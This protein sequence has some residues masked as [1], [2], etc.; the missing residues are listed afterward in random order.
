MTTS[1]IFWRSRCHRP[2]SC[3]LPGPFPG[4]PAMNTHNIR[5]ALFLCV[6]ALAALLANSPALA[7][8]PLRDEHKIAHHER[9]HSDSRRHETLANVRALIVQFRKTGDDQ[10]LDRAWTLLQPALGAASP[11]PETFIAASFVAQSRHEFGQATALIRQALAINAN[12]DE[13]WLLLASIQ[14]VQGDAAS[15]AVACRQLHDVPPLIRITCKAR[16][17][18]ATG[19]QQ[20]AYTR[21]SGILSISD[22]QRLPADT[23]AWSYSVA[24]DLAV[25]TGETAAALTLY[26]RS[27]VLAER[28]QV[29]AALVDVLLSRADYDS[30]W[31]A[32]QDGSLA[33]PLL[34][35]RLIVARHLG[36]LQEMGPILSK[37]QQEFTAWIAKEDWLHAR[38]MARFYIDVVD[39]PDIARRL[40]LINIKLQKEPED[41]RLEARTRKR[42]SQ[43]STDAQSG[44]PG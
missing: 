37:V 5:N 32:L 15:A 25:A 35:R 16:V 10:F 20:A 38:E 11:T 41:L 7:H 8:D 13:A 1:P 34:V 31:E 23:L 30:A 42:A 33:L 39:R 17:A 36:D 24:G 2:G 44:A 29:R 21:L 9:Q 43:P 22:E 6:A 4:Y 19:Q 14:L 28:A 40:A 26:R 27:L 12:N 18:L 3:L